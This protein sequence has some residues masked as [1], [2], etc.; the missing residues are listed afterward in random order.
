MYRITL[1]HV[2]GIRREGEWMAF[3]PCVPRHWRRFQV[4]MRIPGAEYRIT[5]EN[6]HGVNRGVQSVTVEGRPVDGNRV[7]LQPNSGTHAVL[8]TLM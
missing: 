5:V 1:E 7:K 8:V 2:L 3:N 4:T 6:P